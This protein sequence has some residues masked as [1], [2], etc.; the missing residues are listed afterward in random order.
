CKPPGCP[1]LF[2][3]SAGGGGTA[4]FGGT[5][6]THGRRSARGVDSEITA[7]GN[8]VFRRT[9]LLLWPAE[10]LPSGAQIHVPSLRYGLRPFPGRR[11]STIAAARSSHRSWVE[12][13]RLGRMTESVI[14]HPR[15]D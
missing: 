15:T 2:R 3:A 6:S 12:G 7:G 13:S 14:R 8:F 11:S 9:L 5:G 4:S 10:A 1:H